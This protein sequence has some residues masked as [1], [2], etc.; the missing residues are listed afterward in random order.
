MNGKIGMKFNVIWMRL[1]VIASLAILSA[2]SISAEF[3]EA[4]PD[5]RDVDYKSSRVETDLSVPPDLSAPSK[6]NVLAIPDEQ[7]STAVRSSY[8]GQSLQTNQATQVIQ[9]NNRVLPEQPG[10]RYIRNGGMAWLVLQ[11]NVEQVWDKIR[12]FWLKNGFLLKIDNPS[13]GI[14]ETDWMVN[15]ADIPKDFIQGML[16]KISDGIYS[17]STMDKYRIR[18]EKG[19][20]PGT[21]ELY[22][23]HRGLEEKREGTGIEQEGTYW[24]AR[25]S[26]PG[27]EAEM[28][29]QM[30]VFIGIENVRAR[31]LLAQPEQLPPKARMAKDGDGNNRLIVD[32]SFNRAWRYVGLAL[33]RVGFSVEDRDRSRGIYTVRYNDPTEGKKEGGFLSSLAFWKS[34]EEK[35]GSR[36]FMIN[37]RSDGVKSQVV[38]QDKDGNRDRSKTATRI[39]TLLHEQLK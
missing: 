30:M 19:E 29:R 13:T 39:L 26:D 24:E 2:C 15:R 7:V 33:D 28:L 27:L 11:G 10:I 32:D 4:F 12:E 1:S 9:A 37:V 35:P 6:D 17:S 8:G 20:A 16:S 31:R 25:P 23:T 38:V 3:E 18:L 21:T 36:L 22:I 34:D 14:M 5:Q